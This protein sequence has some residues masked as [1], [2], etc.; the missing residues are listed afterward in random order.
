MKANLGNYSDLFLIFRWLRWVRWCFLSSKRV[1][2]LVCPWYLLVMWIPAPSLRWFHFFRRAIGC[3]WLFPSFVLRI[4]LVFLLFFCISCSTFSIQS[5]PPCLKITFGCFRDRAWGF[6]L[7]RFC[8]R[9]SRFWHRE[10][11]AGFRAFITAIGCLSTLGSGCRNGFGG[12][13]CSSSNLCSI[14]RAFLA[15]MT[16]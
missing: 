11:S 15:K 9:A 4:I 3:Q 2:C 10:L 8:H 7:C 1:R 12:N 6:I 16:T 13:R 5:T 14:S